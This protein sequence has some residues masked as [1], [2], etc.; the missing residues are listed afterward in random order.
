MNTHQ[1]LL[2]TENIDAMAVWLSDLHQIEKSY[3]ITLA[4]LGPTTNDQ[5]ADYDLIII[6]ADTR[7]MSDAVETLE[8]LYAMTEAP[9]LFLSSVDDEEYVVE[10][11]EAGADEYIIM[12]I[13]PLLFHAKLEAWLRW[14]VPVE[15]RSSPQQKITWRSFRRPD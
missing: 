6:Q 14:R 9:L 3:L 1:V 7:T 8:H 5:V 10:L 11:Y 12:P 15:S 2:L 13:N 4:P